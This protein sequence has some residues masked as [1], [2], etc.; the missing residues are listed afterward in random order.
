MNREDLGKGT[1]GDVVTIGDSWMDYVLG[2]GGIQAGLD[3]AGTNYRHYALSGTQ[4]LDG[5]I[6]RQY[7]RAKAANADIKTVLMT[8][9][10]NDIMFSGA[11]STSES[12]AA[13]IKEIGASGLHDA[14]TAQKLAIFGA[15][16]LYLDFINLV[17][18][19][20]RIFGGRR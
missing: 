6:P 4:L 5:V 3:R 2:G 9:G 20:L 7:D 12:C 1:G 8:G 15:L 14:D 17:I 19:L 13:K 18:S 10:G 16:R 11:C